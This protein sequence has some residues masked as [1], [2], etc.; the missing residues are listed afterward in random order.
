[1]KTTLAP[2]TLAALAAQ[3]RAEA[4]LNRFVDPCGVRQAMRLL[5]ERGEDWAASVLMRPNLS[6][7]RSLI[8]PAFPWLEDGEL[9]TL[10]LAHQAEWDQLVAAAQTD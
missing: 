1:M 10:I 7:R 9:E 8:A 4:A 2:E 3:G 5:R 6:A